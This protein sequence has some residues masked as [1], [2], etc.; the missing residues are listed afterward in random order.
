MVLTELGPYTVGTIAGT[1]GGGLSDTVYTGTSESGATIL[2]LWMH[3][4]A[5]ATGVA[6]VTLNGDLILTLDPANDKTIEM[7]G[8]IYI[9]PGEDLDVNNGE[10]TQSVRY[11]ITLIEGS[12]A[13]KNLPGGQGYSAQPSLGQGG[14]SVLT[15]RAAMEAANVSG[16]FIPTL[17]FE[18]GESAG[19]AYVVPELQV[20]D[21]VGVTTTRYRRG[22]TSEI[23]TFHRD[24]WIPLR[25][26]YAEATTQVR[27]VGANA[28]ASQTT[29][30]TASAEIYAEWWLL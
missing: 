19:P 28:D 30:G 14:T 15:T 22:D 13:M 24:I 18:V 7:P 25:N 16:I 17:N 5:A 9:A 2:S 10:I 12:R 21:P 8:P 29:S 1:M 20:F 4:D 23:T 3:R 6:T 27:L 11:A 26:M